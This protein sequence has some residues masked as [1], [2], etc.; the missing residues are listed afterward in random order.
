MFF[1]ILFFAILFFAILLFAILL[2]AILFFAVFLVAVGPS[3]RLEH[4]VRALVPA[5]VAHRDA[6]VGSQHEPLHRVEAAPC[7]GV[8]PGQEL[9]AKISLDRGEE[10]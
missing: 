8:R 4:V 9:R 10:P 3:V 7:V 2:F 1:A 6:R 5:H